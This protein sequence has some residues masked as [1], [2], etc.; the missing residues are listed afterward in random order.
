MIKLSHKKSYNDYKTTKTTACSDSLLLIANLE[1]LS[2]P[3]EWLQSKLCSLM[4]KSLPCYL[5]ETIDICI[6][7][8]YNDDHS[9]QKFLRM[10]FVICLM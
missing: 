8:L 1:K 7:S 5:D 6:D 9:P 4:I 2:K 10:F 3:K